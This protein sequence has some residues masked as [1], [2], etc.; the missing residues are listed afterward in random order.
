MFPIENNGYN[1]NDVNNAITHLKAEIAKLSKVCKEKDM[2][3]IK[4]ASAVD[5]AKEIQYSSNNLSNL[6]LQ[7]FMVL[8]RNFE[9]D[10]NNLL[11]FSQFDNASP[12]KNLFNQFTKNVKSILSDEYGSIN[13]PV[14]TENDTIRLLLNKM[15]NY[16][17]FNN[18]NNNDIKIDKI[19]RKE[20]ISESSESENKIS[21]RPSQIKPIS[22]IKIENNENYETIADKFLESNE[23]VAN[24]AYAKKLAN[25][26]EDNYPDPNESGFNLREAV[27]PTEDLSTIMKS[28]NFN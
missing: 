19:K 14:H 7:K 5:K 21:E 20:A 8:Y 24:N 2:I 15:S 13:D 10:L 16:A 1:K 3:N 25:K 11:N 17:K 26:K 27:N 28:F 4:L 6:K 12:M 22:N 23:D 18:E 9:K